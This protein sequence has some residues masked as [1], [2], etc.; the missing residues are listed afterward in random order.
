[1]RERGEQEGRRPRL[2]WAEARA[3]ARPQG[4]RERGGRSEGRGGAGPGAGFSSAGARP[5]PRSRGRRRRLRAAMGRGWGLLVGL[6]GALWLL[7]S[8]HGEERQPETA[9]QRC[10]CQVRRARPA[11]GCASPGAGDSGARPGLR[12]RSPGPWDPAMGVGSWPACHA[13]SCCVSC[14]GLSAGRSRVHKTW[15]S[16]CTRYLDTSCSLCPGHP[17]PSR[18]GPTLGW[19]TSC[20]PSLAVVVERSNDLVWPFRCPGP[21]ALC[22]CGRCCPLTPPP[23]FGALSSS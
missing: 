8:G 15:G 6:L 11:T 12:S 10:F 22:L 17:Q 7:H 16:E 1:M 14:C 2:A 21:T 9:A 20:S 5:A 18:S 19:G 4:R 23:V 13:A 3:A